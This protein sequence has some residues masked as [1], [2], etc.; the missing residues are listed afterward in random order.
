MFVTINS[1]AG[2]PS[3]F[4]L[5]SSAM[6]AYLRAPSEDEAMVKRLIA[7]AFSAFEKY[8]NG[9]VAVETTYDIW[10]DTKEFY[11]KVMFKL[12]VGPLVNEV[13]DATVFDD[14]G[15]EDTIELS[16]LVGDT[17]VLLPLT[18]PVLRDNR[19]LK[20]TAT[21]G[22]TDTTIPDSLLAGIEQ[23]V[24]YLYESRGDVDE[25]VPE[26]VTLLWAPYIRWSL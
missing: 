17:F 12:P 11:G 20:I 25:V 26:N 10:F 24:V 19:S 16:S 18:M 8:T 4:P 9:H 2:K 3:S 15:N 13:T 14:D 1:T 6:V 21:V 22:Y 5:S 7:R 23:Y